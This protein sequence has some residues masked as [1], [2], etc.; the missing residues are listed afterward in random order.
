[1]VKFISSNNEK[2]VLD[3]VSLYSDIIVKKSLTVDMYTLHCGNLM[4]FKYIKGKKT[5]VR[6]FNSLD[7]SNELRHIERLKKKEA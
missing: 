1:M 3:K 6:L 5:L 4:L 2:F 7:V